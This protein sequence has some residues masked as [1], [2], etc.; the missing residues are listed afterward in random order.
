MS[1]PNSDHLQ[2]TQA[3]KWF[4]RQKVLTPTPQVAITQDDL[5][6]ED[7]QIAKEI[8]I[9]A[10]LGTVSISNRED[11]EYMDITEGDSFMVPC[12]KA[13]SVLWAK[14]G[15]ALFIVFGFPSSV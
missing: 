4:P 12:D 13:E 10:K 15:T 3:K 1:E 11:G 9:Y 14:G 7:C 8:H 6:E 2:Y 5:E